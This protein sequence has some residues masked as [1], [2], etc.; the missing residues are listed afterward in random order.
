VDHHAVPASFADP[1]ADRRAQPPPV[2]GVRVRVEAQVVGHGNGAGGGTRPVERGP[3]LERGHARAAAGRIQLG[4]EIGLGEPGM[5][6][7]LALVGER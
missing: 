6:Q 3:D 4:H 5:Q 2:H 1:L 7:R